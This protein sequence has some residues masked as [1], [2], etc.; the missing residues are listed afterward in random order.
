MAFRKSST[1]NDAAL[2]SQQKMSQSK[3]NCHS[4]RAVDFPLSEGEIVLKSAK[5]LECRRLSVLS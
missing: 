4:F 5:P 2:Y 1:F 3:C